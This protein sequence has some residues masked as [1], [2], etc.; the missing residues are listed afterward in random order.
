MQKFKI[1]LTRTYPTHTHS[2]SHTHIN[3]HTHTN[4]YTHTHTNAHKQPQKCKETHTSYLTNLFGFPFLGR[5]IYPYKN[6]GVP[7][8]STPLNIIKYKRKSTSLHATY[9]FS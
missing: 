1:W 4:T 9:K 6:D 5:G 7:K 2:L 3:T 8:I